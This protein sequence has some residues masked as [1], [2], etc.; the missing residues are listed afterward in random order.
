MALAGLINE[1]GKAGLA[2]H[3]RHQWITGRAGK[4]AMCPGSFSADL[5]L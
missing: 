5:L 4:G 3:G 2:N 1:Q